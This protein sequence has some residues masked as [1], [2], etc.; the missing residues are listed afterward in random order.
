MTD[1]FST[2][3]QLIQD[4]YIHYAVH[5]PIYNQ[6]ETYIQGMLNEVTEVQQELI[7]DNHIYL[8][9]ELGDM[10]WDYMNLLYT[11]QQDG[12]IGSRQDVFQRSM[13]KYNERVSDKIA[14][15]ERN[16]TKA[17]QKARRKMEH[18]THYI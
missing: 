7:S 9:D 6:P 8:E 14:G 18:E 3:M 10:L 17:R 15:V 5:E 4:K 2:Y 1:F 12:K 13:A 16:D 11:C